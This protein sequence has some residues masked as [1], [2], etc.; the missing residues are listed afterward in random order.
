[1]RIFEIVPGLFQLTLRYTNMFLVVEKSLTL[2]DTGFRGTMPRVFDFIRSL[3][4]HPAELGLVVLTHNHLDHTGGVDEVRRHTR[5]RILAHRADVHIPEGGM[6]YPQN[7][8]FGV[9]LR[10]PMLSG[11]RRRL[12][13]GPEGVD[14]VLDGGEVLDVMDGAEV[15]PT[16]GHTPGCISLYVRRH[17]L[18][19]VGDALNKRG[20]IVRMP[21]KSVSTDLKKAAESVRRMAALDVQV[22]CFGHGRPI[23]DDP[24]AALRSLVTRLEDGGSLLP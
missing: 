10:T 17:R 9:V 19:M 12:V 7:S 1:M 15:V 13:L 14:G 6:P 20:D 24:G 23:T 16:P 4:R 18:L 5:A 8:V 3:G 21:L 11:F 2:V 22:L